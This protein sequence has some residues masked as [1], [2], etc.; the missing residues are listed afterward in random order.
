MFEIEGKY[1]KAK[2]FATTV[3]NECISQIMELCNQEW[4]EGCQISIMPDCH[5]GKGCTIGTTIKL[6]NKVCP[7]LVGVDIGC[8]MLAIEIPQ[9]FYLNLEHIDNFIVNHIPS[10]FHVN[11]KVLYNEN[12][13]KLEELKCYEYL[14][15]SEYLKKSVGSLG[16]GN[17]FIEVNQGKKGF[18]LVI[19]TGS[20]NLGKQVAEYYQNVA[21]E[22]CNHSIKDYQQTRQFLIS[23]LKAEGKARE[24][25]EKLKEF[26]E[27][28]QHTQK[29]PHDLC[30]LEGIEAQNYLYDVQMCSYFASMNRIYIAQRILNFIAI[31]NGFDEATTQTIIANDGPHLFELA[32]FDKDNH[33]HNRLG[34]ETVHNYIGVDNIL[35]K[36]AISA[37][38]G[39]TVIIP[40][41]M[42]DGSIIGVG[43]GNPSYNFSGP[44]GAG[45]LMNR[46]AAKN[47]VVFKEYQK[48]MEGIY[49]SSVCQST[50]DESPMVY[51]SIDEI[52]NNIE[53][54]VELVDIIKPIYNFKAH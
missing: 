20:R 18:Y 7:S 30:Y 41:N 11:D 8:G 26:D 17:H 10:G 5:S 43:K 15:N 24:I 49:S 50:V 21:D 53:N 54:S 32:I 29:I 19:H 1:N 22:Y 13:F 12:D 31:D 45:R 37:N 3:E 9:E 47:R 14:K 33:V 42:R 27:K 51:K 16:G 2:V 28:Y 38:T 36:G 46:S 44:H 39:E 34:F 6:K 4:L 52:I 35:R 40:M 48:S 23:Q 25:N